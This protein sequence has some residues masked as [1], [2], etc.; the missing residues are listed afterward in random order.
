[1]TAALEA[2]IKTTTSLG[3][4]SAKYFWTDNP[5]GDGSYILQQIPSVLENQRRLDALTNKNGEEEDSTSTPSSHSGLPLYDSSSV[6]VK[7][8]ART[9]PQHIQ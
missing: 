7:L 4:P 3:Q 1:M 9:P 6:K 8:V 5:S 2:Y